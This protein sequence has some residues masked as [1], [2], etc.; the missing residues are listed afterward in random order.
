MQP[1]GK[2][3]TGPGSGASSAW[4]ATPVELLAGSEPC[5]SALRAIVSRVLK[6]VETNPQY[7]PTQEELACFVRVFDVLQV[8]VSSDDLLSVDA[9]RDAISQCFSYFF[10]D[11]REV[12]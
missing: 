5:F 12:S 2:A 8:L 6:A 10:G 1:F 9:S 7:Q 11:G 3:A 4:C